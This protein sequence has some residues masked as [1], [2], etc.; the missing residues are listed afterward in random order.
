VVSSSGVT[1]TYRY[2]ERGQRIRK[3]V[4]ASGTG[5]T[6]S[7]TVTYVPFSFY[8]ETVGAGGSV[9]TR[10]YGLNGDQ[11]AVRVGSAGA[12]YGESALTYLYRDQVGSTI[13]A[14][15][16]SSNVVATR[17][18]YAFGAPRRSTGLLPTDRRFTGQV[19]DATG[20]L[21]YNSRYYDPQLGQFLSPDSLVPDPTNPLDY[22]RYLYAR[23]NPLKYNDPTGHDPLD[24]AW[25]QEFMSRHGRAPTAEDITIRLYSIAFQD[26]WNWSNFYNE[27]G[28]YINGSVQKVLGPPARHTWDDIPGALTNL[29]GWYQENE[30]VEFIRDVGVLF[31]GLFNRAEAPGT[32]QAVTGEG[33]AS[34]PARQWVYVRPGNVHPHFL[35]SDL[36][37]N[38][39]HW[40]WGIVLGS[41]QYGFLGKFINQTREERQ[42]WA[43]VNRG[44][45]SL[46]NYHAD[47]AMGSA[48]VYLGQ[49]WSQTSMGKIMHDLSIDF[50]QAFLTSR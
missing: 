9:V 31:G 39:H 44:P 49:K 40:A 12:G 21:Y 33:A 38:I 29:A 36:D 24:A 1:E 41:S 34:Y 5:G 3:Q 45:D 4:V 23:G 10:H 11:V 6:G 20:L 26:S 19:E 22:H 46:R 13:L 15:D 47:V 35:G 50:E 48:G 25:E 32:W 17:G 7:E 42:V 2:D 28:S 30:N 43:E 27:D 14:S 8:E 16:P 37:S 18:Y